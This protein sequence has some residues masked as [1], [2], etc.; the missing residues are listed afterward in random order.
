MAKR[1]SQSYLNAKHYLMKEKIST[2]LI[3][4]EKFW[5]SHFFSLL[6]FKSTF[7]FIVL[8]G[9]TYYFL[10]ESLSHI[11]LFIIGDEIRV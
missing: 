9:L 3:T 6:L 2:A 1:Y 11:S 10:N 5:K 4:N 7:N 8:N